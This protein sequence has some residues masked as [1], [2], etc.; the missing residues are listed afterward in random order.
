MFV[1]AKTS[2]SSH[3]AAFAH[4]MHMPLDITESSG[5]I[6]L[7]PQPLNL[8]PNARFLFSQGHCRTFAPLYQSTGCAASSMV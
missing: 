8:H 3:P 7:N 5:C 2:R 6:F 4:F 1:A